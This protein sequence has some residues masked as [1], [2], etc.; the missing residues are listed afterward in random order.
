MPFWKRYP[1]NLQILII[2][3]MINSTGMAFLW[4]LHTIYMSKVMGRSLSEAGFVL[5]LHA[6]AEIFGSFLGGYSYD[7]IGAK[8]TLL[9][10]VLATTLFIFI[11][12]MGLTWPIY[13]V[14]MIFLGIGIGT[15]FP[16]IFAL[17]G[18]V[19]TEGGRK[20][21]DIMYLAQNLGVTIGSSLGGIVTD[22]S[23]QWVFWINGIAYLLFIGILWFK[24][25][26]PNPN[27]L[28]KVRKD[29]LPIKKIG[30]RSTH[31]FRSLNVL[32]IGFM[33]CLICYVQWQTSISTY[34]HQLGFPLTVYSSLWTINGL[35]VLVVQPLCGLMM[36]RFRV[37]MGIQLF[38]G[39]V[40]F[41]TSFAVLSQSQVYG[42]LMLAMAI[43]TIGEILIFPTVP[44]I[45]NR[46]AP[47]DKRGMYQG[48]VNGAANAGRTIGP[49]MGGLLYDSYGPI[50]L[51]YTIIAICGLALI[52][53]ATYER[54][55]FIQNEVQPIKMNK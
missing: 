27:P 20:S 50:V 33:I 15:I 53:F 14:V 29:V 35:I 54:F 30:M 3:M 43:M 6:A 22:F 16:P 28:L 26:E 49:L 8:N 23:F 10:S 17:T 32:C 38:V 11:L 36:A 24:L 44:V 37:S 39:V 48:I 13:I 18:L 5:M 1:K 2:A 34:I 42:G 40:L 7:R 41:M 47:F 55:Q 52:C 19:W 4:P 25:H 9:F 46:L 51:L 12:S 21:F 45:A 31:G